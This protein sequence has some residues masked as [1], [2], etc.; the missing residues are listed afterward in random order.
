[1]SNLFIAKTTRALR[2]LKTAQ[3]QHARL[4]AK[5][6]QR[7]RTARARHLEELEAAAAI[8]ACAW[9]NLLAVPGVSAATAAALC[10]TSEAVVHRWISRTRPRSG[11]GSRLGR[12]EAVAVAPALRDA[13]EPRREHDHG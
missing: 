4:K 13:P 11:A 5:A 6:D 2:S 8:E 1:M 10:D 7:L 3:R 12:G 9:R